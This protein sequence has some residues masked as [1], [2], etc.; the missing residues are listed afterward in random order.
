MTALAR[1]KQRYSI[2]EAA[3]APAVAISLADMKQALRVTHS[4]DDVEIESLI[5][6]GMRLVEHFTGR[7]LTT[8][9]LVVTMDDFP[10]S[11]EIY[12]MDCAPVQSVTSI[13]YLDT[14]GVSQVV[15]DTSVYTLVDDLHPP[16][17][18][19]NPGQT[20][21]GVYTR[22]GAVTITIVAGYGAASAVPA[23]MISAIRKFVDY[24]YNN[25]ALS[26]TQA[27]LM[28]YM[29][30]GLQPYEVSHVGAAIP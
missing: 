14:A 11:E 15:L 26:T 23:P 9:T 8:Q 2:S 22:R 17:I 27:A 6:T 28:P 24:H 13:A 25:K 16:F 19:L 30:D 29:T 10:G 3:S 20:W 18:A 5:R 7:R 4:S 1:L 21:P 12:L